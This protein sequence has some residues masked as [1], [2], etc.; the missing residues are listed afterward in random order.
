[1][2]GYRV[3]IDDNF[4]FMEQ[5]ERAEHGTFNTAADAIAAA[6]ALVDASLKHLFKPGMAADALLE[7]YFAFG[8]DPFVMAPPGGE[9]VV[10]FGLGSRGGT[11]GKPLQGARE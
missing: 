9:H 7:E 2:P 3:M 10:F 1:M 4:H 8:Q 11:R 6:K 5:D